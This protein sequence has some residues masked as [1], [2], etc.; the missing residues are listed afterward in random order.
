[1]IKSN[2]KEI[3]TNIFSLGSIDILGML[4]PIVTMP[5]ITR[6]LGVESYGQYLLFMT[7]VTFGHTIIDYGVQ[8]A[9]VRSASKSISSATKLA[10]CYNEYQG[11]R[12]L[13]AILYFTIATIYIFLLGEELSLI[14]FLAFYV[15]GYVL[16]S[17]WF[18]QAIGRSK[19]IL[20][21]S[22]IN[23]LIQLL[24]ILT[25]VNESSDYDILLYSSTLPIFLTSLIL[26]FYARVHFK[27]K[28]L[29]IT[30]LKNNIISGFDIFI[31]LL[32]PN[33]YNS[34]PIMV[35][36]QISEP[37]EFA[38]MAI[39]FKICS[40]IFM[41]QNVISKSTFPVFSRSGGN[42]LN[43]L[44]KMNLVF[45]L[46]VSLILYYFGL[47]IVYYILSLE[48]ASD[49]YLRISIISLVFVAIANSFVTGYFLPN[50]LDK[51]YRDV[52]LYTSVFS[53]LVSFLLV[54]LYGVLGC[55]LGLLVARFTIMLAYGFQYSKISN[56]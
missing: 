9:G 46:P 37:L 19:L 15:I 39:S 55:A 27:V 31:G 3:V 50:K 41:L 20:T 26:H 16:S 34:I 28:L 43:V 52:A 36:G 2:K 11:L 5:I 38:Q 56:R 30:N 18:F 33:L 24:V 29:S 12:F 48:L 45:I 51:V 14:K 40:V 13:L 25:L 23:K 6:A 1:M 53:A 10:S 21:T 4:I 54:C 7:V 44:L 8:Y 42:N 35:V 47:D 32:A 17:V 22:F 49:I